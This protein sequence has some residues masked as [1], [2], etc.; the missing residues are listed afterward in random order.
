[1]N[2]K[3]LLVLGGIPGY[4]FWNKTQEEEI[5]EYQFSGTQEEF[6]SLIHG[7]NER[8]KVGANLYIL[9]HGGSTDGLKEHLYGGNKL[10][11]SMKTTYYKK[12][13]TQWEE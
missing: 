6:S 3:V 11:I 5:E 7:F 2:H 4:Y 10:L 12:Y 9:Q 8:M 1:M 13:G